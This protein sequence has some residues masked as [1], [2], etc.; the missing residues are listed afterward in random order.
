MSYKI[1]NI[2]RNDIE[3]VFQRKHKAYER[4]EQNRVYIQ[5]RNIEHALK[6]KE[7]QCKYSNQDVEAQRQ[8]LQKYFSYGED[9]RNIIDVS[10]LDIQKDLD[11]IVDLLNKEIDFIVHEDLKNE[12]RMLQDCFFTLC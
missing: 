7:K 6:I 12:L 5:F 11:F 3:E 8:F 9:N 1:E 2:I 4:L 10:I